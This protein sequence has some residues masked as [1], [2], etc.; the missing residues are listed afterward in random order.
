MPGQFLVEIAASRSFVCTAVSRFGL[1]T[2]F[3]SD[4]RL[5]PTAN[6]WHQLG[7]FVILFET[8]ETPV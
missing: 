4:S 8:F 1:Q 7:G 5:P 6:R 3:V 2:Y